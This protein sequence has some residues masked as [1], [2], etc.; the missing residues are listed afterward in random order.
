M[1]QQT[2]FSPAAEDISFLKNLS[3]KYERQYKAGMA[4]FPS[5]NKEDFEKIYKQRWDNIKEK[6]DNKEIYTSTPAQQ[7]LDALVDEIVKANP[8]LKGHNFHCYFSRSGIPNASYIGEGIIL[9]NMGLFHRLDNESEAGFIICHELAH[10]LLKHSENAIGKYV[11]A[12]NSEE[13]QQELHKIKG[14]EYRKREQLEKL[15]KGL[16][17]STLRHSRDHENEADSMA[18]ELLHNTRFDVSA[19]LTTLELLDTIDTDTLNTG[20]CLESMFNARNYPFKKRWI[21]KE[22]GLLGGHAHLT[23]DNKLKDSLKTHPDCKLRIKI[24]QPMLNRY[25]QPSSLKNVVDK[26]RFDE[27]K[28]AFRYETI[29]YAFVSNSFTRSFYYTLELLQ[30]NPTDPYLITQTGK[31]LNA[32]YAA[33]KAHTLSKVVDLPSPGYPSNYNLLLQFV[34]NLYLED[35]ASVSYYFLNRYHPELD[36]YEPYKKAFSTSSQI[37]QQ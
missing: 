21:A 10:F 7:Y 36:Y 3:E 37:A 29:E 33:Q 24:L 6:F 16:T 12:I 31:L 18:V 5:K 28:N 25:Y 27:L 20:S 11:A 34:Q 13:V 1:A 9:F 4:S 14:A 35:F 30:K 2:P 32:F 15:V 23:E 17:F 8:I 26:S 19:A 22:E